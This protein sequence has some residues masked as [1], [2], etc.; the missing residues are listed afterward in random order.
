MG[1]FDWSG[2]FAGLLGKA[3]DLAL[4][5]VDDKGIGIDERSLSSL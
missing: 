3:G 4:N 2:A 1:N 5:R